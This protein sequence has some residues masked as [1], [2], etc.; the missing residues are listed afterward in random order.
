MIYDFG[1]YLKELREAVQL[2]IG[3]LSR[4][5]GVSQPYLSQIENGH[6]GI[7]SIEVLK[8]LVEPLK[9][10]YKEF[11]AKAGYLHD[12]AMV[13]ANWGDEQSPLNK[14]VYLLMSNKKLTYKGRLL[15]ERDKQRILEVMEAL[16]P[17]D[18]NE[19]NEQGGRK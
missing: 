11:L 12:S 10:D 13:E 17:N 3:E 6:R 19:D 1:I 7:P 15:T 14:F 5:S 18:E 16:F 4:L 2:S 8:K 9:V